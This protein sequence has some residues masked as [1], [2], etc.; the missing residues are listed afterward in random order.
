M[1]T[2]CACVLLGG[3]V[4]QDELEDLLREHQPVRRIPEG[5]AWPLWGPSLVL[6]FRPE[7]NGCIAVD[8]VNR[9][10]PDDMGDPKSDSVVF[11]A[12][13]M[14]H[15]GPHTYPGGLTRAGQQ[16]WGWEPGRTVAEK[17]R[18]FIRVRS[19]YVFGARDG[20]PV[21]PADY[22]PLPELRLVTNVAVELLGVRTALC[23]F[24]PNGEVLCDAAGVSE[25]LRYADETELPPLN[26]WANV[27]LF[28]TESGW[29]IMDSVGNAQLDLPDVEVC[30]PPDRYDLGQ[31]DPFIRNVT[32]YLMLNGEV[33]RNGH[34]IDGPGETR[35]R[36]LT[37][38][39]GLVS[40]PRR[41]L[42]FFPE[43]GSEPLGEMLAGKTTQ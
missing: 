19:S 33:I 3:P 43:D 23:Y 24:N 17:H 30:V 37:R 26:V 28:K 40:P 2:Q 18:G 9:P 31:I 36:A 20:F 29:L 8:V 10:W 25:R 35:W 34:T 1:F 6:P 5:D 42:R 32:H 38:D 14:G 22:D 21:M 41:T 4:E 39:D 11:G 27:R 13:S 7:V 15:F 16:N 12:W